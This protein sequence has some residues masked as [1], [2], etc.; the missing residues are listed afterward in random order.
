MR[1]HLDRDQRLLFATRGLRLFGYGLLS[2]VLVL[3]LSELGLGEARIGALLTFT[4][5]G[6]AAISL[7][8][9]TRADRLGRRGMLLGGAALMLFAAVLFAV[10]RDFWVLAVAATIGV[11]SPSGNEVGPFLA[12]EQAALSQR[13]L[14]ERRTSVLAWYN[15]VGSL[16]TAVGAQVGGAVVQG[17]QHAGVAALSSYRVVVLGY[18]VVG[19]GLTGLFLLLSKEVEAPAGKAGPGRLVLGLSHSRGVV[20]RLSALFALDA[21]GGG[22]IVQS[23]IAYW[24]HLRFGVEPALLGTIF[25]GANVLAGLS[26][27]SAAWVA[28]RIGLLETMVFTHLPSNV[29]L[30]L[31]PLMP[32][33]PLAIAVLLLRFSISQMDVPTRQSYLMAVVTEEERAAASG[34]TGIARTLGAALAPLLA[35]PLLASSALISL[36]FFLSGGIKIAYD[37]AIYASFK[38]LRPPEERARA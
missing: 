2:V 3:Y 10:T 24:F 18:G 34:V 5:V 38:R 6:D 28:R 31:V 16:A 32:T 14:A 22:L 25:F 13:L 35:A 4:L 17:L 33:L 20:A 15:L 36:P 37:L 8:M 12:I 21:F 27:L 30:V 26:A 19:L 11:I 9:T 1:T 29:L 23:L 7:W